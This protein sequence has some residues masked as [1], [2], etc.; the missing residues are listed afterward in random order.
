MYI[1]ILYLLTI[2]YMAMD[3]PSVVQGRGS[4]RVLYIYI[5]KDTMYHYEYPSSRICVLYIGN[6]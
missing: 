4:Q 3:F 1:Y 5:K 2:K 6:I